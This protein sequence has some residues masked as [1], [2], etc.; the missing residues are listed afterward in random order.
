MVC[1][2]T[3]HNYINPN[4]KY[5][6]LKYKIIMRLARIDSVAT[7]KTLR[8]NLDSLPIYAAS[9]NGNVDMINSY[10]YANYSQIIARGATVDDPLAKRFDGYLAISDTTLNKYISRENRSI[11]MTM[12]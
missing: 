8:K 1:P 2:S 9:V 3:Y 10:F 5:G 11:I 6:P 7:T 12:N 4:I